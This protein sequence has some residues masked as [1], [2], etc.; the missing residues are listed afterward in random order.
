MKGWCNGGEGGWMRWRDNVK[1]C[2]GG[3]KGKR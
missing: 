1:K 3:R 2:R